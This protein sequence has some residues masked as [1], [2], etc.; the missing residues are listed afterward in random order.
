MCNQFFVNILQ[1][2]LQ[3]LDDKMYVSIDEAGMGSLAGPVVS[4][5]VIWH[6]GPY[7]YLINDSKQLSKQKRE[8]IVEYIKDNAIDYQI[9]FVD[10]DTIDKVNIYNANMLSMHTCLDNLDVSFD[11]IMID[12]N[13]FKKY[14]DIE[15]TCYVKGDA[16]YVS[17]AAASILAK[18]ARDEFMTELH[19]EYEI[20]GFDKN[21]GYGTKEHIKNLKLY[22]PCP[23]HRRSYITNFV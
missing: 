5:A 14:G 22:G 18:V 12:G 11:H 6:P 15:H 17:I 10:N 20:Y 1:M 3:N 19:N 8:D 13:K 21:K 16:T 9:S 7:D 4:C 2:L 23:Y